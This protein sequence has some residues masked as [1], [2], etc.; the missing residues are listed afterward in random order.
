MQRI[1]QIYLSGEIHTDWR[2]QIIAACNQA[3]LAVQFSS[4]ITNHDAREPL[5]NSLRALLALKRVAARRVT[6]EMA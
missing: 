3:N 2:E 5:N 4:P 1:W 6:Q